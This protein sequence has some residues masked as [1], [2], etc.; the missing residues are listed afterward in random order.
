ME[1]ECKALLSF[2]Q[3]A[4]HL[5][6]MEQSFWL[7]QAT[8]VVF[9]HL[10]SYLEGL[11]VLNWGVKVNYTRKFHHFALFL[12]PYIFIRFIPYEETLVT[13]FAGPVFSM[14]TLLIFVKPLRERVGII[15]VMFASF[16]RPEDRPHTLRWITTQY[17]GTFLVAIPLAY[18][19]HDLQM[20]NLVILLVLVNGIG[21]GLAE[22][23]GVTWG[24]HTYTVRALFTEKRYTRSLEGSACVFF[25]ALVVTVVFRHDFTDSQFMAMLLL[26][27]AGMTLAEARSPHT[28]DSPFLFFTGGLLMLLIKL[29]L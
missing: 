21:D 29:Y 10:I 12:C 22:P 23:V 17:L 16:D 26:F 25:T 5:K 14:L 1:P 6:L 7:N 8:K 18:A 13:L 9:L 27:P 3:L 11:V 19:Y 20:D 15:R 24:R 4:I 2:H 28:W